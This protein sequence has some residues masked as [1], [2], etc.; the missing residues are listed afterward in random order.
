MLFTNT[1]QSFKF[2]SFIKRRRGGERGKRKQ[3]NEPNKKEK[4]DKKNKNKKT[5]DTNWKGAENAIVSPIS[6]LGKVR[7]QL[8]VA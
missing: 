5:T 4:K 6:V 8:C 1:Q 7:T 2:S 3:P